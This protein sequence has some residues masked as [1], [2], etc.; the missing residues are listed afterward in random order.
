MKSAWREPG[1]DNKY[2]PEQKV[3]FFSTA[4][5]ATSKDWSGTGG[6]RRFTGDVTMC[7]REN[8][9]VLRRGKRKMTTK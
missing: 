1:T 3:S 2:L 4:A 9:N 6:C 5:T 8:Q 7:N